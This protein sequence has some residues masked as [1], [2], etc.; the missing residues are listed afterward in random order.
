MT[1]ADGVIVVG[2]R[3]HGNLMHLPTIWRSV[4]QVFLRAK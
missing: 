3:T 2:D 4:N 1:H